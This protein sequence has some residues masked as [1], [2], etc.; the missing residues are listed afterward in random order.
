VEAAVFD[1]GSNAGKLAQAAA[2]ALGLDVYQITKA[3][4]K[5]TKENVD[6]L[7]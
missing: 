3:G 7:L 4:W 5:L 2:A 6:K 1:G